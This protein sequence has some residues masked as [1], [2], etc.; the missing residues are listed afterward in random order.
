MLVGVFVIKLTGN[1]KPQ[2][3][4]QGFQRCMKKL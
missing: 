2:A 1:K 4:A 3:I